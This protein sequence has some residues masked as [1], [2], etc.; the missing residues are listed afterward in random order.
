MATSRIDLA[1]GHP[2]V[3]LAPP[4]GWMNDPNGLSFLDGRWHA[5]YQHHPDDDVWGPMHWRH[6]MSPDLLHWE[7]QGIALS[8]SPLGAIFSGSLVVDHTN[9]AGFG[10]AE[11]VAIFTL[12]GPDGQVQGVAHS[13]DAVAWTQFGGN[14]VLVDQ[15]Q[16]DFRDPKVL[17]MDDHW[18]M[19]LAVAKEVWFYRSSNL[20]DWE[21]VGSHRPSRAAVG[22]IECPDLA[23]VTTTN[24]EDGYVLVYGDDRGG[25]KENGATF[26]VAGSFDGE[27]FHEWASPDF[28][29]HGPDFYA[30]Q[31]FA[32]CPSA[33]PTV[34]GWMNSWR[35]A[36]EHPSAGRRGVLSLP[37]TLAVSSRSDATVMSRLAVDFEM[38]T[39]A[40]GRT[41]TASP[42]EALALALQEGSVQLHS[43]TDAVVDVSVSSGLVSV[44]RADIGLEHFDLTVELEGSVGPVQIVLDHGTFEAFLPDGRTV[45]MLTFAGANWSVAV[46]GDS[47]CAVLR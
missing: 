21:Q 13:P 19:A 17:R 5:F 20:I 46:S 47:R 16:P 27:T 34:L 29:D 3:H 32:E 7:D 44:A 25:N 42:D 1:P 14:P 41:W 28:L 6:A 4:K 12:D 30:A 22:T 37:R 45:S 11:R 24:G 2:V 9:S 43:D 31:S 15:T 26:A 40:F 23:P 8:P 36:N 33:G 35:Y 10:S 38:T 39:S 18:I